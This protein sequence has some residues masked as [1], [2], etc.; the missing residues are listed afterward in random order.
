MRGPRRAH[1]RLGASE[2]VEKSMPIDE[3]VERLLAI[4]AGT[5]APAPPEAPRGA[6]AEPPP[7]LDPVLADHLER[8][9]EIFDDAAIGMATLTLDGRIVRM[10]PVPRRLLGSRQR[11]AWS[12]RRTPTSRRAARSAARWSGCAAVRTRSRSSTGWPART[13]GAGA[14]DGVGGARRAG[15][16]ALL[17]PPGAGH[18]RPARRGGGLASDRAAL[19]FAGRGGPGLRDLHARP[20]WPRRELERRAPSGARATAPRR[21]SANTS[22]SSTPRQAGRA[23]SRARARG[24]PE[25]GRVRGGGLARPQGRQPVLGPRHHHRSS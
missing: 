1:P 20:Q 16:P 25:R 7:P 5:R 14:G 8:F 11:R 12:A 2:F 21:S 10:Q 4:A 18:D 6:E 17:L 23:A 13:T 9:R 22:G 24:R 3:L 19:P 15:A